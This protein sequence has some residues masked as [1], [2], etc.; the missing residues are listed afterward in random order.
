MTIGLELTLDDGGAE[1][2]QVEMR[3]ER[4]P[5]EELACIKEVK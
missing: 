3:E 4:D 5:G 2:S 1:F